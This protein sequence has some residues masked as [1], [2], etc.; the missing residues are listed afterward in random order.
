MVIELEPVTQVNPRAIA[1]PKLFAKV[2]ARVCTKWP[3]AA[4]KY[5]AWNSA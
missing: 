3:P 5:N 1:R 2:C 4:H